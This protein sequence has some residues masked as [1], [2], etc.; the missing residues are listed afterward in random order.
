MTNA[1]MFGAIVL[2]LCIAFSKMLYKA[3]VPT[4]LIFMG[5]GMAFGSDG[6]GRVPF[7][8]Y[9]LAEN[10]C[11]LAL[12]FI[13]FY[14]GFGTSWRIVKPI[15]VKAVLLSSI[16][17]V[18]TA[19]FTGAFCHY[20]LN[21]TLLEG[22]LIGSVL[23]STD[24]ASVFSI[25]R[26]RKMAL[27]GGMG[28]ILEVESGSND[29]FSYMLTIV[30]LTV[31]TGDGNISVPT[32]LAKQ[33]IFGSAVGAILGFGAAWVLRN[34]HF[35]ID[36]F[37]LIFVMAIAI[38]GFSL[39]SYING[40]GFLC[41]Y[42]TGLIIGSSK[43]FHRKSLSN[44]FD[45]IS[46]L[47]QIMLFF[48]LGLLS[49]PSRLPEVAL[50][51]TAIALFMMIVARPAAVFAILS[52]FRTPIKQQIFISWV[53]IRGAASIAFSIYAV[54]AT[55][56]SMSTDIFHIVFIV[57]LFSV[58]IQGSLIPMMAKKLS[59][60]DTEHKDALKSLGDMEDE[61][62]NQLL[63]F[64]I[65]PN[66]KWANK[67]IMEA[68]LPKDILIVMVKRGRDVVV[69]N[70]STT[71]LPGDVLVLSGSNLDTVVN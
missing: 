67:K 30:I 33:I 32:L 27:Q 38:L 52:P 24:A 22:L 26:S 19:F 31:M 6:I 70:G 5:L 8:D 36:S 44:F 40:N 34:I 68:E 18:F 54:T 7:E 21:F 59:L 37:P 43:I 71:L 2:I 69:P 11:S 53:G 49:F 29:P 55:K 14:G 10:I 65:K 57:V 60:I 47:M 12:V 42:I 45:G 51:G 16:G 35:E 46:W 4:L 58:L 63:E 28:P 61:S 48:M 3:G 25:L 64:T 50:I 15:A 39:S 9:G 23:A 13:M 41:V 62:Y 20:V 56:S 66:H 17:T 1:L